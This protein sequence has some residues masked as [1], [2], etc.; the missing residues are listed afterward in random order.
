MSYILAKEPKVVRDRKL[1]QSSYQTTDRVE[2]TNDHFYAMRLQGLQLNENE[3]STTVA[4]CLDCDEKLEDGYWIRNV[5]SKRSVN[6]MFCEK[7]IIDKGETK[8]EFV[9]IKEEFKLQAR[10]LAKSKKQD[11]PSIPLPDPN[12]KPVTFKM[13]DMMQAGLVVVNGKEPDVP[14]EA[15]DFL[16]NHM[17]QLINPVEEKKE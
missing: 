8:P 1:I 9:P 10:L 16:R 14:K 4:S 2:P 15:K 5:N 11:L 3:K 7:C 6:D 12:Q 13:K 17:M